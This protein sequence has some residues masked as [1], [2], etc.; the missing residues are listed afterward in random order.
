[1]QVKEAEKMARDI[2]SKKEKMPYKFKSDDE[3]QKELIEYRDRIL[4]GIEKEKKEK[5]LNEKRAMLTKYR[6]DDIDY[7]KL[8]MPEEEKKYDIVKDDVKDEVRY[9][10]K[11]DDFNFENRTFDNR[12]DDVEDEDF[13]ISNDKKKKKDKYY[14]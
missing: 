14:L 9:E 8:N 2:R 11:K 10:E 3:K 5:D 13:S 12:K 4:A 6:T 7:K 1:M